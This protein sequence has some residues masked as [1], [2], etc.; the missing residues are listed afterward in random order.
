MDIQELIKA[1]VEKKPMAQKQL[2]ELFAPKMLGVC[3]RY[4]PSRDLAEDVLHDAFIKVFLNI[5]KYKQQAPIEAWIRRIVVN[6]ALNNIRDHLKK[7]KNDTELDN[8]FLELKDE[9]IDY[10]R[11]SVE[12]ML[13][14]L[15]S[16]PEGYRTVFNLYEIEGYS[17]KEIAELLNI[18]ENTSR[19]QLAKA[20]KY[21]TTKL[22]KKE[23]YI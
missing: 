3:M 2:Y 19:S 17:H 5:E 8:S 9:S 14:A 16:L 23:D 10:S 12:D 7:R 6:T 15:Q 13:S 20:K 21:L 22:L 4:M 11:L 1:C 18:S